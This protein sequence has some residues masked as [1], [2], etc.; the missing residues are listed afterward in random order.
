MARSHRSQVKS[1]SPLADIRIRRGVS[2]AALADAVGVSL[3]TIERLEAGRI[4]DPGIR[5]LSNC[6]IALNVKLEELIHPAWREWLDVDDGH[7]EP[8]DP[9]AFLNKRTLAIPLKIEKQML[10]ED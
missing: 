8:P 3:K 5:L 2:Q 9:E 6:A 7:P 4:R 1:W 10:G